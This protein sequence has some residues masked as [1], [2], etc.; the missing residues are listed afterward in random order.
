MGIWEMVVV[1]LLRERPRVAESMDNAQCLILVSDFAC[2][3]S[4]YF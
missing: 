1:G 4:V 2:M 3:F